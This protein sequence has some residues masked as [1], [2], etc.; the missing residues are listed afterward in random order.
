MDALLKKY[1]AAVVVLLLGLAA[2]FQAAGATQ[3]VGAAFV[4]SSASAAPARPLPAFATTSHERR[5][6]Q[7]IIDHNPFDSANPDLN[8]KATESPA[9]VP[10]GPDLSADPLSAPSCDG[11]QRWPLV[12]RAPRSELLP[13]SG[14]DLQR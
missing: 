14:R 2:Y 3:L 11:I 9:A 8:P 1:F 5:S 12:A 4:S 13:P 10:T 7:P 6:A